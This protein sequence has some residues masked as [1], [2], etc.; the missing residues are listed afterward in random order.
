MFINILNSY[1]RGLRM[2]MKIAVILFLAVFTMSGCAYIQK[3]KK[4]DELEIENVNL[5]NRIAQLEKDKAKEVKRV[6]EQKD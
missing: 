1:N 3:A 5:R 6:H 2:K 4:T